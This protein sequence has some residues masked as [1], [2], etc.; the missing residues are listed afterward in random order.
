MPVSSSSLARRRAAPVSNFAIAAEVAPTGAP[1]GIVTEAVMN[2]FSMEGK[3][4]KLVQPPSA[5]PAVRIRLERPI[6]PVT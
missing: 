6:A 5:T 4:R 2:S 1:S 3:K